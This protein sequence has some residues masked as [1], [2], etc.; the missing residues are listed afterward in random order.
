MSERRFTSTES[1][2]PERPVAG[3]SWRS[4]L[5]AVATAGLLLSALTPTV[6]AQDI[7]HS[8]QSPNLQTTSGLKA[9]SWMFEISHRFVPSISTGSDALWGFDGPVFNRFGLG[10]MPIDGVVLGLQRTNF[11]DNF[12][13]NAKAR[14]LRLNAATVPVEVAVMTGLAWNMEPVVTLGAEDNESQFYAQAIIDAMVTERVALGV[15]P[16]WIRNPRIQDFD[17]FNAVAVGVH[18][19]VYLTDAMS[20]VGE[21]IFSED[22]E[23]RGHDSGTFGLEFE[24]RGHFF[25]LLVTNQPLM[26][27]TQ[28]LAG[29]ANPFEADELRFGFNIQRILPF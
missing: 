19:Q 18:G 4:G 1:V 15:V 24:T 7:F 9:G 23:D 11:E 27:P 5:R 29:S 25:K 28:Y 8:T 17:A 12:E 10:Y 26:N 20:F 3:T 16:T 6:A 22:I 13:L 21:W 14:L 2:S